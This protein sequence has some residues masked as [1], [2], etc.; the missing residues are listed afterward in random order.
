[1][2]PH[3]P[4]L[5]VATDSLVAPVFGAGVFPPNTLGLVKARLVL[6]ATRATPVPLRHRSV[7]KALPAVNGFHACCLP[8]M[9]AKR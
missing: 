7:V 2:R 6:F 4:R 3:W 1:M 8:L 9:A 5:K